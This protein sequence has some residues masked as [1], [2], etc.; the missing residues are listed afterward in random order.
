MSLAGRVFV[1]EARDLPTLS[2]GA[3]ALSSLALP[4]ELAHPF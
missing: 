1:L 2:A 4:R 3:L